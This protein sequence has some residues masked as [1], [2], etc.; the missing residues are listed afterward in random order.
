MKDNRT[1]IQCRNGPL[2]QSRKCTDAFCCILYLLLVGVVVAFAVLSASALK[3]PR[4]Q[5]Q[6][7]VMKSEFAGPFIALGKS[8]FSICLGLVCVAAICLFMLILAFIIPQIVTYIFIPLCLL[9]SL[10]L[11]SAFIYVYFGKTLPFL[12]PEKQARFIDKNS[13]LALGC[14]I[15]F[16]TAFLIIILVIITKK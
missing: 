6:Q 11:G 16:L 4:S 15:L 9:L 13:W 10:V 7:Q 8:F 5:L 12:S 1:P 3:I 2:E 14:G